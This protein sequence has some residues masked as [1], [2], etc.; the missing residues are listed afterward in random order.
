MSLT[1]ETGTSC[2]LV[3]KRLDLSRRKARHR[4][5]AYQ[6]N[7]VRIT[8]TCEDHGADDLI[9]SGFCYSGA[10]PSGWLRVPRP[11]HLGSASP[12]S[13]SRENTSASDTPR[14]L[15]S[16]AGYHMF[17]GSLRA[18]DSFLALERNSACPVR[19]L[20]RVATLTQRHRASVVE[21]SVGCK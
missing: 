8:R 10:T 15:M 11:H 5:L 16:S 19:L 1:I 14:C 21:I 18:Q 4:G 13:P 17:R 2:R 6:Y 9:P 20:A 12:M 3:S 7:T